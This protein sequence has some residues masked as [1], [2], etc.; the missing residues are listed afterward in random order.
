MCIIVLNCHLRTGTK[1]FFAA[2]KLTTYSFQDAFLLNKADV[3]RK[4]RE[5]QRLISIRAAERHMQEIYEHKRANINMSTRGSH[6]LPA[7]TKVLDAIQARDS[8][9]WASVIPVR[10]L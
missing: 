9:R 3:L 6:G 5:R 10:G 2:D 4:S 7:K 1:C 8:P